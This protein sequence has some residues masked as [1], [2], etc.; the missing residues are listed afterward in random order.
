MNDVSPHSENLSA[1]V[2]ERH[3][4]L[5][6]LK[7][8]K[9]ARQMSVVTIPPR[10]DEHSVSMSNAFTPEPRHRVCLTSKALTE[11]R[12]R[13]RRNLIKSAGKH[14]NYPL[15]EWEMHGSIGFC[16][17]ARLPCVIFDDE[18]QNRES[19]PGQSGIIGTPDY[20]APEILR[21]HNHTTAVD[22]WSLGV[23]LYEFLIGCPPFIDET[24]EQVFSNILS[25]GKFPA[26]SHLNHDFPKR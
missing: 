15:N 9:Q 6:K 18:L 20:L 7:E 19:T 12:P 5:D 14:Q 8:L 10:I 3:A 23:C 4:P 25:R 1:M 13:K 26:G 11:Y 17:W 2:R 24:V 21:R 22:I 16:S